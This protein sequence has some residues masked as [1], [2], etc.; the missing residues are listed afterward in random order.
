VIPFILFSIWLSSLG[1]NH[2]TEIYRKISFLLSL[3]ALLVSFSMI[4]ASNF[5]HTQSMI[6]D[7]KVI[8]KMKDIRLIEFD[9]GIICIEYSTQ[10]LNTPRYYELNALA[11]ES[12]GLTNWQLYG[13]N[14][15]IEGA[16]PND[17]FYGSRNSLNLNRY[18]WKNQYLAG[19]NSESWAYIEVIGKVPFDKF[20]F[21]LKRIL[22]RE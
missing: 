14:K 15:C 13:A 22:N 9:P 19:T 3:F 18:Q 12:T 6:L 21:N 10:R 7:E 17:I 8:T 4:L 1:E 11:W 16:K 5:G 2:R 20:F